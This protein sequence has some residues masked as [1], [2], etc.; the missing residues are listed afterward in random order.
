MFW[1]RKALMRDWKK[2]V[3]ALARNTAAR[4]YSTFISSPCLSPA[5]MSMALL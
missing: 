1:L 4:A 5:I 2:P 3:A